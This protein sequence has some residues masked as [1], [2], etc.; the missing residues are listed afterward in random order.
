MNQNDRNGEYGANDNDDDNNNNDGDDDDDEMM[1]MMNDTMA[2][3]RTNI[4]SIMIIMINN[5][6]VR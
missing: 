3:N 6:I 4:S 2:I 5:T 1:M